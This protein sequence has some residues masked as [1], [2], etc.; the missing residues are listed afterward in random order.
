MKNLQKVL[1]KLKKA[2]AV[3]PVETTEPGI[4]TDVVYDAVDETVD[5]TAIVN[6]TRVICSGVKDGVQYTITE[7]DIIE[8]T[9]CGEAAAC[10]GEDKMRTLA[11][12][13]NRARAKPQK[14]TRGNFKFSGIVATLVKLKQY[15]CWN[16]GQYSGIAN[17]AFESCDNLKERVDYLKGKCLP[18]STLPAVGETETRQK[19]IE[20]GFDGPTDPAAPG[21]EK[22]RD[23]RYVFHYS[24]PA[25]F[26]K[27]GNECLKSLD[28]SPGKKYEISFSEYDP[29]LDNER[30]PMRFK[31]GSEKCF[32]RS[33]KSIVAT[34][35]CH[36]YAS[37]LD[38]PYRENSGSTI[39]PCPPG[40]GLRRVCDS[41]M[42]IA[43]PPENPQ[44]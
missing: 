30:K 29:I 43:P 25:A 9:M 15:S 28:L 26:K 20:L 6:L 12:A 17:N 19:L 40:T 14:F 16:D 39:V 37:N 8:A 23:A 38:K 13:Y 42:P 27:Q 11:V 7:R 10:S 1:A 4:E 36:S 21:Y 35:G 5:T 31:D 32:K 22:H 3:A 24:T 18:G 34:D 41:A 33:Y 2:L 44:P